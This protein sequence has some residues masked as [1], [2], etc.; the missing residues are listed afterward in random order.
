MIKGNI[1]LQISDKIQSEPGVT[2]QVS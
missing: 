2:L 1:G